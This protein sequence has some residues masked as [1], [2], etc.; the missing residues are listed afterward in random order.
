MFLVKRFPIFCQNIL[1]QTFTRTFVIIYDELGFDPHDIYVQSYN[2]E[3]MTD[4][5]RRRYDILNHEQLK[6]SSKQDFEVYISLL[7]TTS[8]P[9]TT[10]IDES[11]KWLQDTPNL[12]T[13]MICKRLNKIKKDIKEIIK[14]L[15]DI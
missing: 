3:L 7:K 4:Y 12:D 6:I 8:E 15:D 13:Y 5:M 2:R 14:K 9:I 11:T 10:I 1:Q